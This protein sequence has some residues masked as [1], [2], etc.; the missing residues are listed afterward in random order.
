MYCKKGIHTNFFSILPPPSPLT[1]CKGAVSGNLGDIGEQVRDTSHV[2]DQD[3]PV[4]VAGLPGEMEER[5][6]E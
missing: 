1:G 4:G 5:E 2:V 3:H 6:R